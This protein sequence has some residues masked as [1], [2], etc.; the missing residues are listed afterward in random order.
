MSDKV[1]E[2]FEYQGQKYTRDSSYEKLTKLRDKESE[3]MPIEQYQQLRGWIE[4]ADRARWSRV[5]DKQLDLARKAHEEIKDTK[6]AEGARVR[7]PLQEQVM[8]NPVVGL[9][10]KVGKIA[11]G[12]LRSIPIDDRNRDYLQEGRDA[13]EAAKKDKHQEYVK[14]ERTHEQREQ[15]KETIEQLDKAIDQNQAAR[16]KVNEKKKK[17]DRGDKEDP[18]TFDPWGQH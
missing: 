4:N 14:P 18:T 8:G 10:V 6:A 9:F 13:L 1:K 7:N 3:R 12:L 2:H 17:K 16:D 5:V 15:D 11:D